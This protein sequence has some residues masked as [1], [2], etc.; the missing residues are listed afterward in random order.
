MAALRLHGSAIPKLATHDRWK[1][2]TIADLRHT[3]T[4]TPQK[5]STGVNR[6]HK[7]VCAKCNADVTFSPRIHQPDG[8]FHCV[9]CDGEHLGLNVDL[10][11][12][13]P[14]IRTAKFQVAETVPSPEAQGSTD[15]EGVVQKRRRTRWIATWIALGAFVA[16]V[17]IVVLYES[18]FGRA[19][20]EFALLAKIQA[21]RAE[22][23]RLL[24]QNKPLEAYDL[25]LK[26]LPLTVG[27]RSDLDSLSDEIH[28]LQ[29]SSQRAMDIAK[30][31]LERR[32][33]EV[34][35][36]EAAAAQI[37][38]DEE[39]RAAQRSAALVTAE[40]ERQR[41]A[42]VAKEQ[43]RRERQLV[44]RMTLVR[45][46]AEFQA[47]KQRADAIVRDLQVAQST[48]DSAYRGMSRRSEALGDLLAVYLRLRGL[49]TDVD[50]EK[51][52]RDIEKKDAIGMAGET[53]AIRATY[54]RQLVVMQLVGL[55]AKVNGDPTAIALV[56]A[57][58]VAAN[59]QL[60]GDDSA[61]RA[62]YQYTRA[63]MNSVA[64]LATGLNLGPEARAIVSQV[65][66]AT[67]GDDSAWRG[68]SESARGMKDLLLLVSGLPPSDQMHIRRGVDRRLAGEDSALRA[69]VS[70]LDG[71]IEVL[72]AMID[73]L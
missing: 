72:K 51:P 28:S 48:E 9:K 7:K 40:K 34:A 18:T 24:A 56:Q 27:V 64:A 17:G 62:I 50:V 45:H 31:I 37:R 73:R 68:A 4:V 42:A 47:L 44:A 25:Y 19:N 22:P 65:E 16:G 52:I 61:I 53:S 63:A 71:C 29:Q 20:R 35:A 2:V 33:A 49:A 15:S 32:K 10:A 38:R 43:E 58:Q 6:K 14:T 41:V 59:D 8:S 55:W 67:V 1:V 70:Q 3:S 39:E 54:R 60:S 23:D 36:R 30:P 13:I 69:Y 11:E 57:A 26:I 5:P 66:S 21:L 12:L 46:T